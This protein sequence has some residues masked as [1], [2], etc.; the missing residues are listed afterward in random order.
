[1]SILS[2]AVQRGVWQ[3]LTND[4]ALA[5]LVGGEIHD[6][7][8]AGAVPDL[9][10]TLGPEDVR[11]RGDR[12]VAGAEH[13]LRVDVVTTRDGFAAAKA[14]A[15]AI[16][17]ALGGARPALARGRVIDIHFQR[18]RASQARGGRARRIEMTFRILAED[19]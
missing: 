5:A 9:Y 10:V 1:M 18:A 14:A 19:D 8:P 15:A 12:G 6:G 2:E 16:T 17:D 7:R 4:A 13:R 3:L 11:A